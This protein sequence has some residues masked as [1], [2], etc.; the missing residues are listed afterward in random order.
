MDRRP[1]G[2]L[3]RAIRGLI[4]ADLTVAALVALIA[5]CAP[6]PTIPA[7]PPDSTLVRTSASPTPRPTA[8][9]TPTAPVFGA[10]ITCP[11]DKWP[12]FAVPAALPG[13]RVVARTRAN[14]QISNSSRHTYY[15]RVSVWTV[16][17]L[18]CGRGLLEQES[19]SG[20]IRPGQTIDTIPYNMREMPDSPLTV[21]LWDRR[22]A[23]AEAQCKRTPL[24]VIFVTRSTAE[25][26]AS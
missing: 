24:A 18:D 22:C 8:T 20:P 3:A 7:V 4:A 26:L 6:A 9:P 13:I 10:D 11:G 16:D 1:D 19:E 17:R 14:L 15:Y 5:G 21:T 12:P 25:P 23:V 2:R